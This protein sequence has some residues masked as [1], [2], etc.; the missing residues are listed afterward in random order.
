[1]ILKVIMREEEWETYKR[2][3]AVG[4]LAHKPPI[5]PSFPVLV[6]T[7]IAPNAYSGYSHQAEHSFVEAS[8]LKKLLGIDSCTERK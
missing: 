2:H 7:T 4:T 8:D 1:M 5:P 3:F 6:A